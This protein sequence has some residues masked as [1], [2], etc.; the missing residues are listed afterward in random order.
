MSESATRSGG[1]VRTRR[2]ELAE[3][4]A[5][6]NHPAYAKMAFVMGCGVQ[7]EGRGSTVLDRDGRAFLA[8][9]DQ[10]GKE[11]TKDAQGHGFIVVAPKGRAPASMYRGSAEQD[12]ID[13]MAEVQRDYKV[14]KSRIYLMGH[15]MGG[16]GT[17]SIAIAHPDLFAALGPISGGGDAASVNGTV[18]GTTRSPPPPDGIGVMTI[19]LP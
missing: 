8:M 19:V 4:K 5:A 1:P 11:L 17:W 18:N 14:D 3:A 13:V 7:G 15:S 2:Q 12:V 10:Y 9:F 16:Y 6:H